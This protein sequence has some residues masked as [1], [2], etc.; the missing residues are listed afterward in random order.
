MITGK[1]LINGQ[2]ID[3]PST[4]ESQPI[5]GTAV[6][7]HNASNDI[8]EQ[9]AT[10]ARNSF[11][12]F[13]QTSSSERAALLR[14]MAEQINKRGDQLSEICGQET[15]LPL[16]R[17]TGERGRTTGQLEM[18]ANYIEQGNYLQRS[19]DQALPERAPIPRPDL[20]KIMRPMG[21]VVVFGA[22]NFPLAF[23]TA[24]G[25]TASALAAGC[26]VIVKGH[27]AHPATSEIIAQAILEAIKE[28]GMDPGIFSLIQDSGIQVA[29][30]LVTHSEVSAVGFT[31]SLKAGRILYNL[32]TQRAHPI[33]FYGEMGS[34]N[35]VFALPNSLK[36][37]AADIASG[38]VDSLNLGAGQFCTNPGLVVLPKG[39]DANE[40]IN[41][42]QQKIPA[43]GTC[44][45]LTEGIAKSYIDGVNSIKAISGIEEIFSSSSE[46]NAISPNVLSTSASTWINNQSLHEEV[47]GPFALIIIAEDTQEMLDVANHLDGQLTATVFM[48]PDDHNAASDLVQ[49]LEQ[50]AG[51]ILANGYPTG[52]E[53][54]ESMVHGGPYPASTFVATTSVGTAAIQR[55]L[56]PVCYQDMPDNLLPEELINN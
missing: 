55:F 11:Q 39:D 28:C 6:A 29:Q 19:H 17:L 44:Q 45:M 41:Q 3:G 32:C 42:V 1:H 51:R 26:P 38:W 53:V 22:S 12:S 4:F 14:C 9:S 43:I 8:V 25:D 10:Q 33:P 15:G 21:P 27:P 54:A 7:I 18:F 56:R 30:Q 36:N 2:W 23:S 37:S 20:K 48:Q 52:V 34:I 47:F 49:I 24:G 35:P 46:L 31:G 5:N 50:K 13:A 40:F 16:A